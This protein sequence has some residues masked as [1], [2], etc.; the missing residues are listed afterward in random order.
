[1]TEEVAIA[2]AGI[3]GSLSQNENIFLTAESHEQ[4]HGDPPEYIEQP[5]S[6]EKEAVGASSSSSAAPPP[7]QASSES[8]Q[9]LQHSEHVSVSTPLKETQIETSELVTSKHESNPEATTF[10]PEPVKGGEPPRPAKRQ[11]RPVSTQSLNFNPKSLT[12][13]HSNFSL[14]NPHLCSVND[15]KYMGDQFK[16][17]KFDPNSK[18]SHEVRFQKMWKTKLDKLTSSTSNLAI[19]SPRKDIDVVKAYNR[20]KNDQ[21]LSHA[22]NLNDFKYTGN[23]FKVGKFDPK[24]QTTTEKRFQN[25]YCKRL[26]KLKPN[27]AELQKIKPLNYQDLKEIHSQLAVK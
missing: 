23:Q 1:M 20:T 12:R 25:L 14:A 8:E 15:F 5:E 7:K 10:P 16:M 3:P 24:M 11:L 18:P 19:Y 4:A 2:N 13:S 27:L 9:N 6:T 21:L 22:F 17:G 26:E